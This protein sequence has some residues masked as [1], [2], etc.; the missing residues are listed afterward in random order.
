MFM[1]KIPCN[2]ILQN[3]YKLRIRE[4]AQL[5]T[6]LELYDMEIRQKI[7]VPNYQKLKT[8]VKRSIDQKL[9]LRIFDSR[10]GELNQEQWSRTE[11]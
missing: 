9:R 2:N 6:A 7:S 8:M 1:S 5:K 3:L 4:S 11:R 10:H